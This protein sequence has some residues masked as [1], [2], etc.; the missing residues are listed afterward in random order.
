[1]NNNSGFL[2]AFELPRSFRRG[3]Y[4]FSFFSKSLDFSLSAFCSLLVLSK[5]YILLVSIYS[6]MEIDT[7]GFDIVSRDAHQGLELG[8]AKINIDEEE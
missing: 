3:L 5:T 1:M 2:L 6:K 8:P 4:A 7:C